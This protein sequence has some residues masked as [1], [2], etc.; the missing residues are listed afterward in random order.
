MIAGAL[1]SLRPAWIPTRAAATSAPD[2][3]DQVVDTVHTAVQ[4]VEDAVVHPEGPRRTAMYCA[5][6]TCLSFLTGPVAHGV[7]Q[8]LKALGHNTREINPAPPPSPLADL[9]ASTLSRPVLMVHG[10]HTKMEFYQ[11]LTDKLTEGGANGGRPAF[12]QKGQLFEDAECTR[13]LAHPSPDM[14]VFVSVFSSHRLAPDQSAP[15]L[16]ANLEAVSRL[17]GQALV[18]VSAYS[19]GG[20]ATRRL[21]DEFP[22][23]HGVGKFLMVGT[24]NQGAGM[25][26]LCALTLANEKKGQDLRWLLNTKDV[27]AE[28]EQALEWLR[29]TSALREELN[30]RWPT[31]MAC[32]ESVLHLGSKAVLTPS[33]LL[34]PVPGDG[35]VSAVSLGL[36]GMPVKFVRSHGQY[37]S[38]KNLLANPDTYMEMRDHFGWH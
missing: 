5:G 29:P 30:S 4:A 15:E 1:N 8:A 31:Q 12:V 16:K 33:L 13:P 20:L 26:G 36:E 37:G 27:L 3:L 24:P 21:V 18:D 14:R 34:W 25:A 2:P 28:D 9:P 22:E 6:R 38:H 35:T 23:S 17:T 10:W 11:A 19:M 7:G 32:F